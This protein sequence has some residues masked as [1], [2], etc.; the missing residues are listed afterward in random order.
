MIDLIIRSMLRRRKHLFLTTGIVAGIFASLFI[1]S[2]LFLGFQNGVNVSNERLGA[3]VVILPKEVPVEGNM[4]LLSGEPVNVYFDEKKTE[5]ALKKIPGVGA[6]T[7][8]F[9]TQTLNADCCSVGGENRLVGIDWESDFL[10]KPWLTTGKI[11]YFEGNMAIFGGKVPFYEDRVQI[12]G[13]N[14]RIVGVLAPTGTAMDYTI[15]I[16]LAEARRLTAHSDT[17]VQYWEQDDPFTS[18]SALFIKAEEGYNPD[19]LAY[20]LNRIPDVQV[21]QSSE[22]LNATRNSFSFMEKLLWFFYLA[23]LFL[24]AIGLIGR[25]SGYVMERKKEFGLMMALGMSGRKLRDWIIKETL[26]YG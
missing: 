21:V 13:E 25:Y 24:G 17:V 12:L 10:V 2:L 4:V 11:D 19:L 14:F 5:E 26:L 9:F 20:T 6:W 16:P 3:D 23:L 15:Y 22:V 18:L 7:P 8:Q 1:L